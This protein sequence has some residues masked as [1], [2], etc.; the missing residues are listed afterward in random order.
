MKTIVFDLDGTLLD[1]R[2]RHVILLQDI[3]KEKN[4]IISDYV[5]DKYL[6]YKSNGFS[7]KKFLI[8]ECNLL[9]LVAE[10]CSNLWA[11]KIEDPLYLCNDI[12]YGDTLEVLFNL[13]SKYILVLLTARN[14]ES[15][16]RKQIYDL[17]IANYFQEVIC[18]SPFKAREEKQNALSS[19]ENVY[20]IIGDTEIDYYA[21]LRVGTIF[22]A[23]NRGFRSKSYWNNKGIQ[24][25]SSLKQI[26][27]KYNI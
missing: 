13:S 25:F 20:M 14:S 12:L 17:N 5:L 16:L 2:K 7:T 9:P 19:L 24:S 8:N 22:C 21:S 23:L 10:E 1:S 3:L 11:M 15:N 27:E 4:I 6:D 18:V 26:I